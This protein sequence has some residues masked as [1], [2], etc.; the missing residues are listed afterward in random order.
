M[1]SAPAQVAP[2]KPKTPRMIL[3]TDARLSQPHMMIKA[4]LLDYPVPHDTEAN[5]WRVN[6]ATIKDKVYTVRVR[7][8]AF[9][10]ECIVCDCPA[11]YE[12]QA[13]KHAARVASD[14]RDTSER[15]FI[16]AAIAW[17]EREIAGLT[18]WHEEAA[19]EAR[20]EIETLRAKLNSVPTTITHSRLPNARGFYTS[21]GVDGRKREYCNGIPL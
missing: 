20:R 8:S 21:V 14:L 12:G 13:C 18:G 15:H 1:Q 7:P 11:G 10:G 6:S 4:L 17:R 5:T 16:L 9:T 3:V 2:P 19:T